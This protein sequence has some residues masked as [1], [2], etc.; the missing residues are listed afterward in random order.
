[1]GERRQE[2]TAAHQGALWWCIFMLLFEARCYTAEQEKMR[3]YSLGQVAGLGGH[4]CQGNEAALDQGEACF[5]HH[6]V[7][8]F[9]PPLLF[10]HCLLRLRDL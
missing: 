3:Q 9:L 8:S 5:D 2:P 6:F 7:A 4:T 10:S 1:M